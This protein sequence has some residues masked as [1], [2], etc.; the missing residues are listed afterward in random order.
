[1]EE[2]ACLSTP[3]RNSKLWKNKKK[4]KDRTKKQGKNSKN[5]IKIDRQ[6]L[7]I[8][9]NKIL[10]IWQKTEMI[11]GQLPKF[12]AKNKNK[13]IKNFLK[14]KKLYCKINSKRQQKLEM[15]LLWKTKKLKNLINLMKIDLS[16]KWHNS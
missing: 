14:S 5:N 11:K 7:M 15:K 10:K 13:R 12:K 4:K 2:E 1:M 9:D 8:W 6:R 3:T 16:S